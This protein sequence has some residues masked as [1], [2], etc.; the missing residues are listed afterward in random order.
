MLQIC[1]PPTPQK[2]DKVVKLTRYTRVNVVDFWTRPKAIG[3]GWL[4]CHHLCGHPV[5][6]APWH[7]RFIFWVRWMNLNQL[8][9]KDFYVFLFQQ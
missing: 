9:G 7:H 5:R 3:R 2:E 6:Q 8:L 1:S 4:P